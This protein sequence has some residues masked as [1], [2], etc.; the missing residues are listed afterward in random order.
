MYFKK[1]PQLDAEG[2]GWVGFQTGSVDK[3]AFSTSA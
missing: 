1:A 3:T 2:L